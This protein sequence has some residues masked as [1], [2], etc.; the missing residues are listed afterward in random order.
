MI[1]F[2][3]LKKAQQVFE[4][5]RQ[6]MI[7]DRD[8]AG[9]IQA[10]EFC[11]ELSWKAMKKALDSLGQESASPKDTFRKAAKEKI[12]Q[13]P[14][15]WFIFQAKRNLVSHTYRQENIASILEIFDLFSN[16]LIALLKK[17]EELE[18]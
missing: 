1:R 8:K 7:T 13:D 6:D 5:F 12:I 9:A 2:E 3:N 14:E 11:Y 17:L 4:L 18:L 15:T 10:F 16:E